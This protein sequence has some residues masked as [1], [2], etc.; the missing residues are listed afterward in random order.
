[1]NGN[2]LESIGNYR[3]QLNQSLVELRKAFSDLENTWA[4]LRQVLPEYNNA[5]EIGLSAMLSISG[6]AANKR[7]K[8]RIQE[9]LN[10]AH[11]VGAMM[12]RC[13]LKSVDFYKTTSP[14]LQEL[15]E[16]VTKKSA[17]EDSN[18][19]KHRKRK[20]NSDPE[21]KALYDRSIA[22]ALC[23]RIYKGTTKDLIKLMRML[24]RERR[25]DTK[26]TTCGAPCSTKDGPCQFPVWEGWI[27]FMH[28]G[29][30]KDY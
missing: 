30:M 20:R 14:I 8:A 3:E 26:R 23:A 9:V 6:G 19:K 13:S 7:M 21:K 29:G 15:L 12:R 1:M 5:G 22:R 11:E 25:G 24:Y 2:R 10:R 27:C 18:A 16:I 17:R 4:G 28:G